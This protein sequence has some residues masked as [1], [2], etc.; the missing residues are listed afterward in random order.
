MCQLRIFDEFT[1][2]EEPIFFCVV[3]LI[4]SLLDLGYTFK[5][6]LKYFSKLFSSN[7]CEPDLVLGI[8]TRQ[9]EKSRGNPL[10]N[11]CETFC[12]R[13]FFLNFIS[14]FARN[15][16]TN[17]LILKFFQILHEMFVIFPQNRPKILLKLFCLSVCCVD[18]LP[19]SL[20]YPSDCPNCL[21]IEISSLSAQVS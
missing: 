4:I 21:T 16:I 18:C 5:N 14:I 6:L 1:D 12:I 3:I 2:L 9:L 10:E 7:F 8:T 11:F 13:I 17:N 19:D 15:L 20:H